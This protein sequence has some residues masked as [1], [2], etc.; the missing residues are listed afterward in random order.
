MLPPECCLPALQAQLASAH[1]AVEAAQTQLRQQQE[2]QSA[3]EK[4]LQSLGAQLAE[5]QREL[6]EV[7]A[8]AAARTVPPV[9]LLTRHR[10]RS[11]QLPLPLTIQHHRAGA[12]CWRPGTHGTPRYSSWRAQSS[13]WWQDAQRALPDYA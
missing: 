12:C 10:Q 6:H 1:A 7:I 2:A 9:P 4:S 8:F 3:L 11:S 13:G 5:Q